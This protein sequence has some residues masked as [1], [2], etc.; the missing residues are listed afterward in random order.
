MENGK[1]DSVTVAKFIIAKANE[2]G[3]LVNM[4]KVQKLLYIAYG[5]FLAVKGERLTDEHPQ[6]W[7]FGPV[8]PRTRNKLLKA[9]FYGI[10][11]GNPDLL[12]ISSDMEADSLVNSVFRSFGEW[13]ASQLSEWSHS[14]GSPWERTVSSE[15]FKWGDRI[16]DEYIGSYFKSRISPQ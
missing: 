5:I 15:G 11:L 6:A 2:R 8:F 3:Y 13:S 9:D 12:H 4:T 1:Y 16:P 14:E 7:P 10:V